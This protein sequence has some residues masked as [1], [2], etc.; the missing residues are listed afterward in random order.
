MSEPIIA[1][2]SGEPAG[3]GPE[4]CLRLA[5]QDFGARL[6]VLADRELLADRARGLGLKLRLKD[7]DATSA[8]QR[9]GLDVLPLPLKT[10]SA[11]GKL[12]PANSAYVLA[13]LD[14]ALEGCVAGKFYAMVTAP[15]HKAVI[16]E[17]GFAFTG[18][19]EYLAEKTGTAHVVMMLAGGGL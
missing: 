5:G 2:T 12:N 11:A 1:V 3:V 13:L 19:T 7:F 8:R 17:A 15:V 9:A 14:R 18:H 10:K 6:V 4:L 16:N